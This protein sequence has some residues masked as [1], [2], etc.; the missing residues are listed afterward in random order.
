MAQGAVL[1]PSLSTVTWLGANHDVT[2]H[3]VGWDGT[4]WRGFIWVMDAGEA[5]LGVI[6][7]GSPLTPAW[8]HIQGTLRLLLSLSA[9]N[10]TSCP[11]EESWW[12]GLVITSRMLCLP[13]VSH[14]A[15]HHLLQ[16][17]SH[18]EVRVFHPALGARGDS[19]WAQGSSTHL[20][21]F[22]LLIIKKLLSI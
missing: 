6:Y 12:S 18:Q 1:N 2:R 14:C 20:H 15:C 21:S 17:H 22:L 16:S 7:N 4:G 10:A 5:S 11:L 8:T 9:P 19:N 3:W 13:S